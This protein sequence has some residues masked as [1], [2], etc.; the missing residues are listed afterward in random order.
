MKNLIG[1]FLFIAFAMSFAAA[2]TAP[3]LYGPIAAEAVIYQLPLT[4]GNSQGFTTGKDTIVGLDSMRFANKIAV[5]PGCEYRL[6]I[7]DS[8]VDTVK[9]MQR[10][11]GYDGK[12]IISNT[13]IDSLKSGAHTNTTP[14]T[15]QIALTV[16]STVFGSKFDLVGISTVA[17]GSLKAIVR[18]FSVIKVKSVLAK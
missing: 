16:N 15:Q 8:L 14:A 9:I 1:L 3:T 11:Y 13:A 7:L 2:P 18:Y 4:I 5:E 17:S 6:N 10:V 12:T